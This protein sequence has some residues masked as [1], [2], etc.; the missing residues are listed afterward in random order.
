MSR[1]RSWIVTAATLLT[2]AGTASLGLW[3]LDRAAQKTA[4]QGAIAERQNLAPWREADLIAAPDPRDGI[5]RPVRLSGRWVAQATV[6]L[7]NRQMGGRVGFFVVTPLRLDGSDRA[8]LVQRGWVPR[9]F[10]DRLRVPDVPTPDTP[11]TVDG[12]LASP[13]GQLYAFGEPSTG[14]IR[15]NIALDAF[16]TETGLPLLPVSVLQTG[17]TG[18]D[19]LRQWP[20]PAVD[21]AKHHGYAFQ[22]F[23]LCTLA[24]G[25]YLWFQII[26]P[27][28]ARDP[29]HGPDA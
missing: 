11:V 25:L 9:D 27:R 13:P 18:E 28:R 26:Q 10:Q 21:V 2:V 6:F 7:E 19:L 15:Q 8:V 3:Q 1:V 17:D 22:W 16:A 29:S 12:R 20:L 23:A 24:A 14:T 4:L 5:H